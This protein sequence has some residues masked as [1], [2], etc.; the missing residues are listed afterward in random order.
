ME[1]R[2]PDLAISL[3]TVLGRRWSL[4]LLYVLGDGPARFTQ[5]Q[6]AVPGLSATSLNG[7]LHDLVEAGLI[8]RRTQPGPPLT[9]S[10]E[11]T[12]TGRMIGAH[13]AQMVEAV[14]R[15]TGPS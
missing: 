9:S 7:R 2:L 15:L 5:L 6:R 3:F 13:L 11:A 4:Q 14:S 12:V 8:T 1:A 10:Y